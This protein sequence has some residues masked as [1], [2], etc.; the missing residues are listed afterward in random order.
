MT[1][2]LT[3]NSILKYSSTN[4]TYSIIHTFNSTLSG[5]AS[6]MTFGNRIVVSDKSSTAADIY[7]FDSSSTVIEI[8]SQ[9]LG[10]Y[11]SMP[12]IVISP[13][14]TKIL[15]YGMISSTFSTNFYFV[16]Y[17]NLEYFDIE[18]PE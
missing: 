1:H 4:N 13:N 14:C 3:S 10:T 5:S 18:F 15:V 8:L 2:V 12:T 6:I 7:A 16:D 17:A 11:D 9:S